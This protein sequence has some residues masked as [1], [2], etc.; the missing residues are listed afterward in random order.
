MFEA[1][2]PTRKFKSYKVDAYDSDIPD[3]VFDKA[4]ATRN[5]KYGA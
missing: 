3:N 2:L 5:A 4:D 1:R